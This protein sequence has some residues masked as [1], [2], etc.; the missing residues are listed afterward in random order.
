M[1]SL[2][3]LLPALNFILGHWRGWIWGA[4]GVLLAWQALS[5]YDRLVD[6]P[7]IRR[8][9]LVGYV[10][11]AEKTAA[12]ALANEH[13]RQSDIVEAAALSLRGEI[14]S[15]NARYLAED[16]Q[17]ARDIAS[18]QKQLEA[19]VARVGCRITQSDLDWLRRKP[20]PQGGK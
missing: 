16:L 6:D 17:N 13:K 14:K 10:L 15:M 5:L 2:G 18:Y 3:L 1:F 4:A 20:S 12:L 11:E 8:A 9:A 19:A 7:A